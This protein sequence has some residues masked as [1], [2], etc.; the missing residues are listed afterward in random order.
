MCAI[1]QIIIVGYMVYKEI[2][3]AYTY[4]HSSEIILPAI[5]FF[6]LLIVGLY[7]RINKKITMNFSKQICSIFFRGYVVSG[8]AL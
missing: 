8:K 2:T 4:K 7:F 5:L 3:T 6:I 1:L